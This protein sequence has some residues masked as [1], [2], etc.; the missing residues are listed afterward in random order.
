MPTY[1][2]AERGRMTGALPELIEKERELRLAAENVGIVYEVP[3][4]GGLRTDQDQRQLERWRDEAVARGEAWYPVA[5]AGR[6]FHP[7]GGAFDVDIGA[8]REVNTDAA[9]LRL[10]QLGE[11]IGLT[12]GG[13]FTG[14][15][16]RTSGILGG[17]GDPFHFQLRGNL[18]GIRTKWNAF[19]ARG[20]LWL[21]IIGA[22][23]IGWWF[24]KR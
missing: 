10:G 13:R 20:S 7:N 15:Q 24:F 23:L 21:G 17:R 12:W 2:N 4:F 5:P 19:L 8:H 14:Q 9:Y 16:S 6:S 11:S 22:G 3:R 18:A 1:T